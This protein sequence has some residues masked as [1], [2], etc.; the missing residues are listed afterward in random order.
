ML[1]SRSQTPLTEASRGVSRST[2]VH[3]EGRVDMEVLSPINKD[4]DYYL[5]RMDKMAQEFGILGH[6][7]KPRNNE[8]I[9]YNVIPRQS[10][11][12]ASSD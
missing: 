5:N 1:A 2:A 7:G 10:R 9:N 8:K 12:L 4:L 11:V 6:K 3:G